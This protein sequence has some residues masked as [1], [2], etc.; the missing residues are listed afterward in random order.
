MQS[1]LA[2]SAEVVESGMLVDRAT[3]REREVDVLIRAKLGDHEILI[4]VECLEQTRK[5]TVAWVEQM[6]CKHQS[7]DTHKL[8]LIS[9]SGFTR[10]A[11]L[12][13]AALGI[14]AFTP[15]VASVYDWTTIAGK[16]GGMSVTWFEHHLHG[17]T[18][19]LNADGELV[20]VP[21]GPKNSIYSLTGQLVGT[22]GDYVYPVLQSWD[23]VGAKTADL[24]PEDG[25]VEFGVEIKLP[26]DV[27]I[28]LMSGKPV[29]VY[30]LRAYITCDAVTMP[31]ALKA[32][33]WRSTSVAYGAGNSILGNVALTIF[34]KPADAPTAVATMELP[35]GGKTETVQLLAQ[36][37]GRRGIFIS[38]SS[39]PGDAHKLKGVSIVLYR[40]RSGQS[41]T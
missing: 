12:K 40:K 22:I 28:V 37:K 24:L 25:Q 29:Q 41:A 14:E 30:A 2:P 26:M 38:Q 32:A 10:Q 13:A 36:P 16:Q 39:P 35:I 1:Q 23:G 3:R 6:V 11:I 20:E 5:A 34:E 7:L 33:K 4:S 9:A 27:V 31:V 8:V 15:E 17:V 21:I 18:V 19:V